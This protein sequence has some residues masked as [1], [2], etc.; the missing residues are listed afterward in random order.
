MEG[1]RS[2]NQVRVLSP[3]S[4]PNGFRIDPEQPRREM[5]QVGTIWRSLF[6]DNV[7]LDDLDF[8]LD[9]YDFLLDNHDVLLLLPIR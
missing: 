2:S 5:D 8:I 3:T 9:Y 6:I 1:Y 7:L 4:I